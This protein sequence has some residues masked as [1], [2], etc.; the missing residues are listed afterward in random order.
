MANSLTENWVSIA[1]L[2]DLDTIVHL[3][4]TNRYIHYHIT[5]DQRIWRYLWKVRLGMNSNRKNYNMYVTEKIGRQ[6]FEKLENMNTIK[7][8]DTLWLRDFPKREAAHFLIRF[9]EEE[10]K[11]KKIKYFEDDIYIKA[12]I[13]VMEEFNYRENINVFHN[14]SVLYLSLNASKLISLILKNS[15]SSLTFRLKPVAIFFM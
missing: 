5:H 8:T 4:I 6:E 15:S 11:N 2:L 10:N 9:Y 12:Y 3:S 13:K 14:S 1:K 7:H